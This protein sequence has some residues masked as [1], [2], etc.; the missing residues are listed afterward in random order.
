MI[1]N[2]I[3]WISQCCRGGGKSARGDLLSAE[4]AEEEE[5]PICLDTTMLV[6][7]KKCGHKFCSMCID[8]W[9]TLH[10]EKAKCP[11]CRKQIRVMKRYGSFGFVLSR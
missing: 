1:L 3:L 4:D 6:P 8:S 5:C 2:V 10:G 9:C 7:L 11:L